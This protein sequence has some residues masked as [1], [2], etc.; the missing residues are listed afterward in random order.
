M[1]RKEEAARNDE[2]IL[3]A[4]RE[5]FVA[6]PSAPVSAVAKAAGVGVAGLYRRY[7]SKEDLLRTLA[8]IGLRRYL[9]E[10]EAALQ[11]ERDPWDAFADWMHRVI[12][13]DT[14]ALAQR[15]AGTFAPTPEQY[16]QAGQ[17]HEATAQLIER[18]KTGGLRADIGQDDIAMLL[19]MIAGVR[20]G[21]RER[22]G[23]LRRRYLALVLDALRGSGPLPGAPPTW[24]ELSSRWT[25]GL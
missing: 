15:L 17:A 5:V 16:H 3:A 23:E 18:A 7:P 11:D 19:E 4:A 24:Q 8:G 22:T 6:D 13:A 12:E 2:K 25:S 10:T 21:D 14:N 20:L 1:S 9:E